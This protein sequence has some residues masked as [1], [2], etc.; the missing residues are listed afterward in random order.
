MSKETK[1][2]AC[3]VCNGSGQVPYSLYYIRSVTAPI[4]VTCRSC[5]GQGI[6]WKSK[7]IKFNNK[8]DVI[9]I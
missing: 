5:N 4:E 3:P 7:Q 6:I 2:Y 1:P 8:N 9:G